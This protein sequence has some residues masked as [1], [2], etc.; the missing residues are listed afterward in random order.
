MNKNPYSGTLKFFGII[1][2]VIGVIFAIVGTLMLFGTIEGLQAE[3]LQQEILVTIL[4]YI[5]AILGIVCGIACLKNLT[6]VCK[7]LGAIYAVLGLALMIYTDLS[8]QELSAFDC[9][10]MVLGIGIFFTANQS[11]K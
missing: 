3:A 4:A 8:G 1:T 6:S 5:E 9:A 7:I 11:Q 2:I 10:T